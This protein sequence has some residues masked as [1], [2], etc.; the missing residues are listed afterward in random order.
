MPFIVIL[1][2]AGAPLYFLY[3]WVQQ[4]DEE[5]YQEVIKETDNQNKEAS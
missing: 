4:K 1:I 2:S 3:K 5:K